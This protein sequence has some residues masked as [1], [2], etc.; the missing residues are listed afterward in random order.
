MS[1]TAIIVTYNSAN[2]I[3]AALECLYRHP[4]IAE[5]IVVD[6]ASN[7]DTRDIIRTQFPRA[8]LIENAENKG[9]GN[10]CNHGLELVSTDYALLFN[11]D[12][13][14]DAAS[15]DRLEQS[16][17]DHPDAAIIAPML[18]GNAHEPL[19]HPMRMPVI[20]HAK[21][22]VAPRMHANA[23]YVEFISGAV[24]M[25]RMEYMKKV[26]F[27]DPAFFLFY[28]DDDISLRVRRAG[29]DLVL[30][31]GLNVQH[32]PGTSCALTPE[33]EALKLRSL[34]WADL[35]IHRKYKGRIH[36]YL[37]AFGILY[38][39]MRAERECEDACRHL[40]QK[41]WAQTFHA[42]EARRSDDGRHLKGQQ[43]AAAR[44]L[45]EQQERLRECNEE[46]VEE[47]AALH[48]ARWGEVMGREG[49]QE[50][51]AANHQEV[52]NALVAQR[53]KELTWGME[54]LEKQFIASMQRLERGWKVANAHYE[55]ERA[56]LKHKIESDIRSRAARHFLRSPCKFEVRDE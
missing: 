17:A 37:R 10:G 25:W 54:E 13:A 48:E 32:A 1:I 30:L 23:H 43:N 31:P 44:Y 22:Q 21:K 16:F 46:I 39:A 29:Y 34:T 47:D 14:I 9:F 52:W 33:L 36:A 40:Y 28:E 18:E 12:A 11:P 53:E 55:N 41:P 15:I 51:L 20:C 49:F 6:N 27:F 3:S 56:F 19:T 50:V 42:L 8:K 4:R 7:D 35:Y 45:S 26:G 5:C 2:I 38:R 24:A